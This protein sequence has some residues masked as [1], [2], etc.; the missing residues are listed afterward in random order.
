M[1]E[2]AIL[3][4][5]EWTA[6]A[7]DPALDFVALWAD[8]TMTHALYLG[9]DGVALVR[10]AA[11]SGYP[12]LSPHRPAAA[13]FERMVFDLWGHAA[14]DGQP[15]RP[16]LDH[17]R[18]GQTHPMAARPGAGVS[19][20]EPPEFL[21]IQAD[22]AHQVAMGPIH[23]GVIEAGHLRFTGVGESVARLELR[24]GYK[25]KGV[26]DL[27]RGKSP[28]AAARYAARLSGDATV[29]HAIAY[30]RAAEDAADTPA[31]PRA[32]T[33]RG[34]MAELERVANHLA[35]VG[36]TVGQAG[37]GVMEDRAGVLREA[38]LRASAAAFGHRLMMD[39]VIPGGVASDIAPGGAEVLRA[40]AVRVSDELRPL[41]RLY[42]DN[43]GLADRMRGA[44]V[45]PAA[46]AARFA[47]GGPVGR[48]SG[49]AID[50]RASGYPPYDAFPPAVPVLQAGDADS[51]TLIR[52]AELEDSLRLIPALLDAL[53]DGAVYTTLPMAS[54]E[55]VGWSESFRGDCWAWLRLEGGLIAAAFLRDPSWI[56]WPL[57]EAAMDGT[58]LADAPLV[59]RS[60]GASIS[61]VDL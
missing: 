53:P 48:A 45:I 47:A 60:I 29:A 21:E 52:L 23:A 34:V 1:I 3:T 36:E 44:G 22:D 30:A 35:A 9:A 27:M 14:L 25:H 61:G 59:S 33:L 8:A 43:A 49:R 7:V 2:P 17:G 16:W 51:R 46:L 20:P 31:P 38:V 40:A 50:A 37:L 57:L 56:H 12:A 4:A 24:L 15:L 6:L 28:R 41:A 13:W 26:L 5:S 32:G 10:T 58:I 55:G 42:R 11:E 54:G 19:T 18:W 39:Q